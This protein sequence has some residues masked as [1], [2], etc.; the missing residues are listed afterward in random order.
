MFYS[1]FRFLAEE[2]NTF[3]SDSNQLITCLG[4]FFFA[5]LRTPFEGV[6]RRKYTYLQVNAKFISIFYSI[7]YRFANK[8]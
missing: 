4:F 2:I 6:N 5:F 8:L 7:F 3:Q 1:C